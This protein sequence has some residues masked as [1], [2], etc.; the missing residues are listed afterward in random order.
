[1]S[2][3]NFSAILKL[4]KKP[5]EEREVDILAVLADKKEGMEP[6]PTITKNIAFFFYAFTILSS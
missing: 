6:M 2:R 4:R 3:S 5:T 1:V